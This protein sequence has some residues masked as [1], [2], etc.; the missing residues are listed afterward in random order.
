MTVKIVI[1]FI[2]L[3]PFPE[4]LRVALLRV[5]LAPNCFGSARFLCWVP[6]QG[7]HFV[8]AEPARD[9]SVPSPFH[10]N[11]HEWANK[12]YPMTPCLANDVPAS[13]G[14]TRAGCELSPRE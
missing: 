10:A 4:K 12:S 9:D 11:A 13:C 7:S 6:T 5:N 1:P 14:G 2:F 8:P 3:S